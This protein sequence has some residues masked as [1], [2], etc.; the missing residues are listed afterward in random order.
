MIISA[1]SGSAPFCLD[2]NVFITAWN[3]THPID[4]FEPL[5]RKM[6]NMRDSMALLK[7]IYD[8]IDPITSRV[9]PDG[10]KKSKDQLSKEHGLRMWLEDN[11]FVST[12]I[13]GDEV[14]SQSLILGRKYEIREPS[15]GVGVNDLTLIAYAQI[16]KKIVVTLEAKQEPPPKEKWKHK[17]PAVCKQERVHCINF[18]EMLRELKISI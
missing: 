17:I 10:V 8:E 16:H 13:D 4:I 14:F 12:E 15:K 9:N 3:E 5:W 1:G 7:P 2:A 18:I 6:A 11:N